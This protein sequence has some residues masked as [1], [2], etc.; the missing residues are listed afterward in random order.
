MDPRGGQPG[1][2]LR[3]YSTNPNTVRSR[4]RTARLTQYQRHLERARA[5]DARALIRSARLASNTEEFRLM[6]VEERRQHFVDIETRAM[7][8]R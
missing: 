2:A 3:E 7:D 4:Q 1:G 5:M 6:S 8:S